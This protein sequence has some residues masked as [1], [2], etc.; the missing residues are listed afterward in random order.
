[1]SHGESSHEVQ[2]TL[3]G[4]G[5]VMYSLVLTSSKRIACNIHN[6]IDTTLTRVRILRSRAYLCGLRGTIGRCA[7]G[8]GGAP[9]AGASNRAALIILGRGPEVACFAVLG[10]CVATLTSHDYN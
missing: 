1:M 6:T 2:G 10:A 9:G 5:A 4:L 3:Q 7:A 8:W